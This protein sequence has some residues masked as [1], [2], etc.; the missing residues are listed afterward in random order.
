MIDFTERHADLAADAYAR[1]GRGRHEAALNDG[2]CMTYAVARLA[3][4]PLLFVGNGFTR[5]DLVAVLA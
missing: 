5:T 4:A 3:N 2:D 1:Y